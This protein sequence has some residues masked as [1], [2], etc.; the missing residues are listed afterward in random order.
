MA[1]LSNAFTLLCSL[2]KDIPCPLDRLPDG[3]TPVAWYIDGDCRQG[4]V[5]FGA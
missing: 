3:W 5:M 1:D 4:P 2:H